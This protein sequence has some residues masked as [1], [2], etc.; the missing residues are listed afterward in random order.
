MVYGEEY[1]LVV[2]I[3][4]ILACGIVGKKDWYHVFTHEK[5]PSKAD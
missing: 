2:R 4:K 1:I 3:K 5:D